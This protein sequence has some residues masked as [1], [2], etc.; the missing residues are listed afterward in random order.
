MTP[1]GALAYLSQHSWPCPRSG[2]A[3][4]ILTR[5][6]RAWLVGSWLG[7]ACL[8]PVEDELALGEQPRSVHFGEGVEVAERRDHDLALAVGREQVMRD[9]VALTG[10]TVTVK[11]DRALAVE[12]RG[13]VV[14]LEVLED[15]GQRLS[16]FD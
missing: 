15:L 2:D 13:R 7:W 5:T 12:V 6:R 9:R 16:A 3:L 1:T 14:L 10:R 8:A 4:R 11:R